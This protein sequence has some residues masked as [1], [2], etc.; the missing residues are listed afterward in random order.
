MKVHIFDVE[1]GNCCAIEFS[2][3]ECMMID[4]GHNSSTGWRPSR[5]VLSKGG[6][7]TNLTISNFMKTMFLL[8]IFI[9]IV[10]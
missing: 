9:I 4:C 3:G 10:I 1:H 2:S 8:Q 5:W 7:L 6:E